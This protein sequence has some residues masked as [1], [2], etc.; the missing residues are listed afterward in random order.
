M[1]IKTRKPQS[2][3]K[4]VDLKPTA[5]PGNMD[6]NNPLSPNF[7]PGGGERPKD[8]ALYLVACISQQQGQDAAKEL[9]SNY[10]GMPALIAHAKRI[11]KNRPCSALQLKRATRLASYNSTYSFTFR[12]VEKFLDKVMEL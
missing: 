10:G 3:G 4:T 5:K 1:S 6:A 8:L 12:Y 2:L 7:N 11:L 9:L